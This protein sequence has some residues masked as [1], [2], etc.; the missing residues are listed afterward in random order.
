MPFGH[1]PAL[2]RQ[3]LV[4]LIA[5]AADTPAAARLYRRMLAAAL[6]PTETVAAANENWTFAAHAMAGLATICRSTAGQLRERADVTLIAEAMEEASDHF[7]GLAENAAL[8]P[9]LLP[10]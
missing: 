4:A 10:A 5:T 7:E 1:D 9:R 3:A 2:L 6:E 8:M